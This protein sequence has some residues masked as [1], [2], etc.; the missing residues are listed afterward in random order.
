MKNVFPALFLIAL[1]S[2]H[3]QAQTSQKQSAQSKKMNILFIAVDDLNH[4]VGYLDRNKQVKT[5]N[6][7]RLA[8]MGV[9]FANAYCAA[10]VCCPSRA[11]LMSGLRPSTSGV[12]DN[13]D[14]WRTAIPIDLPMTT[15]FR[16]NGY[17]VLGGGKIYHG[18]YDRDEEFD[19]YFHGGQNN[20]NKNVVKKGQFGG[21][22]WAQLD[23]DDDVLHDYHVASWAAEEL[24]KKHDKPLFLAA[25]IFRPHMPWNVPKKYFDLYPLDKI[26]LPPYREDDLKDLPAEGLKM[27]NPR[28]DHEKIESE[29]QWKEAIQAYQACI[30]YADAQIGRILDA[31]EKSPERDHTMIVLWG[32]HGWHLG[33]KHHWRKFS[34]WEEATRAPMMWYVPGVTQPGTICKQTVDFMSIYPTLFSL[35]GLAIPKHNEGVSIVPLLKNP[36]AAWDTPALTT[37]GENNHSVRSAKWRYIRYTKGGEELYDETADPYEWTN[38][39]DDPK[40]AAVKKDLAKWLPKVN[41]KA[42]GNTGKAASE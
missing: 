31:Y 39:A 42:V 6:L 18:G 15:H 14:D 41:K 22:K 38:L 27:A 7:D 17:Q 28:Q 16:K 24:M 5:P 33:E 30:S 9:S 26:E 34:L 2:G 3:P 37:F 13:G 8:A 19:Y 36:D 29:T 40:Y 11:A 1:F 10:P 35:N 21:I 12:Y 23:A 20:P 32:D 25:G 4:W